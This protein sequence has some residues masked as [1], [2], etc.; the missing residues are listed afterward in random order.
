MTQN[1]F[2]YIGHWASGPTPPLFAPHQIAEAVQRVREPVFILREHD[3]GR[4]GLGFRG[5]P[6]SADQPQSRQTTFPLLASLPALFP[7][8][9]GDRSFLEAHG[10]RFP[11]VAGA[12]ANGIATADMVIAMGKAQMLGFFGAAGLDPDRIEQALDRIEAE[13]NPIGAAWGSNLI[14]SPN[15]PRLEA[16]VVDL[17]LRRDVRRVSASAYM[18]LT[19]HVVRY[20]VSGLKR[21]AS[22]RIQ[23]KNFLFAKISRPETAR[24]FMSPPPGDMLNN[25]VAAG[26]ISAEEAELARHL[27]LA[28]DFTV[29]SDSGGHTDNRPLAALFPCIAEVRA[30][31]MARYGYD[32]PI[33]LGAAGGL[34]TP[35]AVAAAFALGAAFVL[36]GS[37]NQAAIES[38]LSES[39]K[40]LLAGAGM[41]DVIM[42]PAADMFE[43]GVEVQVLKRGTMFGIRAHKLYQLYSAYPGLDDLP[44]KERANL[45]KHFFKKSL[46]QA[47]ADTRDFWAERD[48]REVEKAE[49]N[50]KHRMALVFRA[51][52][53][54]SSRWAIAGTPDRL[55]DYQIWCGPAMG[56]FNDWTRDSFLARPE[57]RTVT[58]IAYN[59]LEGAAVVTR[60]HQLRSYGVAVPEQAFRYQPR[61]LTA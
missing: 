46:E 47:W 19:P 53:G 9:L 7:E 15:E 5:T 45:E 50:P 21:D 35:S 25:L 55:M 43:L 29:E 14:H 37:V 1:P 59:L 26:Q 2:H 32:R 28:E 41:A 30:E 39:G 34:G 4:I 27:P 23:R 54:L 40:Q 20:A 48:P 52:L 51:Y 56:A 10:V 61:P 42:A 38:G 12:M 44:A 60:A 3:R 8:W 17:Y 11:Y 24:H 33:R 36:T 6:V 31:C 49:A 13:L 57:N 58:Q 18:K 22:G 16:A